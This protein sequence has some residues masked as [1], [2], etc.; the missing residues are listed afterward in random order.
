MLPAAM[1]APDFLNVDL[2]IESKSHLHT[3]A[4]EFGGRVF[5]LFSGRMR[6]RHCL[7]VEAAGIHYNRDANIN[8]LCAL[9]EGLSASGRRVWD[10]ADKKE[11]DLGYEMRLSS[12]LANRFTIRP[13]ILRR[14]AVLGATVAVTVYRKNMPLINQR[15]KRR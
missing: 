14:I 8:D 7:Y 12:E 15:K 6:G 5:V 13:R 9:V 11:F 4:R 10:K 1:K 3:L 2:V